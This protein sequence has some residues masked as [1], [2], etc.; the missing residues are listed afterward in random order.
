[1]GNVGGEAGPIE[2]ML[3]N[4]LIQL[5]ST[6]N[7]YFVHILNTYRMHVGYSVNTL[8]TSSVP[9]EYMLSAYGGQAE[10]TLTRY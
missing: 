4:C 7:P 8:C 10:D 1:M 2:D 5:K 6:F 9:I 3:N